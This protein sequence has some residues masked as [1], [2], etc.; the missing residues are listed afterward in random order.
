MSY[1]LGID[2][3]GTYTDGVLIDSKTK[4]LLRKTKALTTKENLFIGINQCLEALSVDCCSEIDLIC[5]STTLATNAVVEDKGCKTGLISIGKYPA[6]TLPADEKSLIR[7]LFSINGKMVEMLD[8]YGLR[9]AV[10]KMIDK[11]D[12]IAVSG[13]ASIRN[14]YHEQRAKEII[15]EMTELPV[16]CAHE[17]TGKLGFYERTVTAVLNVKLIPIIKNLI[18]DTKAVMKKKDISAPIMIVKG[19]GSFMTSNCAEERAI[20][21]ILSGPAASII[22]AKHLCNFHNATVIDIGGTTSDIAL[23]SDDHVEITGEG[24]EVGGWKTHVCAADIYTCGIGGDSR[25]KMDKEG[26][27]TFGPDKTT[28]AAYHSILTDDTDT[29][30]S[31][32]DSIIK[33]DNTCRWGF[34]PTDLAHIKGICNDWNKNEAQELL[35]ELCIQSETDYNEMI[36]KIEEAFYS[37]LNNTLN[38]S[39]KMTENV[40][41]VAIGAP[42]H[43]WMPLVAE[44]YGLN[45]MVPEHAE[46]ANAVGAAVGKIEERTEILIRLDEVSERYIVYSENNR[47]EALTLDDAKVKGHEMAESYV[48]DKA[49]KAGSVICEV[50]CE[51]EDV[52]CENYAGTTQDYI[53]TRITAVAVGE[54]F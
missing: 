15:E 13:Y 34:T 14:P 12:A 20:E 53:E 18:K 46:V 54:P 42:S 50:L 45:V 36:V 41:V 11:V 5:L 23:I 52:Y 32:A 24:A 31:I 2:T 3:G 51:E 35:E 30:A 44:K 40:D 37:A 22:G 21:T 27:I 38:S 8:E 49:K 9:K 39:G 47:E 16:V 48:R 33:G 28:P 26:R 1:I 10:K 17:L 43:A 4:Q 29:V 19:D 7:G 25:M 6:G